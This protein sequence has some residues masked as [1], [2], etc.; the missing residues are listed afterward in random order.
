MTE[1]PAL[2][3]VSGRSDAQEQNVRDGRPWTELHQALA[4][5]LRRLAPW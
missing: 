5:K 4:G 3:T 2:A 1:M